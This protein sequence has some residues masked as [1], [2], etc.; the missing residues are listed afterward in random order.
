MGQVAPCVRQPGNSGHAPRLRGDGGV[1][2]A[3]PT[4]LCM[5]R[6]SVLF[7]AFVSAAIL[8]A[9]LSPG[10]PASAQPNLTISPLTWNVIGLDSNNVNVG[11]DNFP[12]GARVCNTGPDPA[13]NVT[14]QLVWDS[15]N[16]YVR[17][18]PGS[19][20]ATGDPNTT[21]PVSIGTLAGGNTCKDVYFEVTVTRN[22]LAYDTTRRY[23]IEVDSDET[24]PISTPTP[25]ELYVEHLISQNR[26]ATT[27]VRLDG[28]SIPA[29]GT[30][31]LVVGNTYT[32]ELI[33]QTATNGY[34][35]IE[36]FIN[37]PNTIFRTNSVATTYTANGGT[38][39]LAASKL[40]ADGCGWV[41]DP[42]SPNYRACSST[43]KYGGGISVSYNVTII[44]GGGTTQTLNTLIYDFS[45]SSYHYNADFST[46]ARLAAIID[47]TEL[48]LTKNFVPDPTNVNGVSALTFTI[49]N[50]NAAAISGLN[51]TDTFPTTPGAM[52]V[53]SPSGATTT[54]CGTPTFAPLAGAASISF[55]NG[56]VAANSTCTIKVNVTVPATGT[57]TNTSNH[58]FVATAD[59]GSFA[60]DTLTVNDSPPPAACTPGFLMARWT[61]PTGF[62]VSSPAPSTNNVGSASAS[63][64]AGVVPYAS[65]FDHTGGSSLSWGSDGAIASGATLD[66]ANND[67]FE[68]A[69]NTTGFSRVILDFWAQRR[70][71]NGPEGMAVYY[72][73]SPTPPGTSVYNNPNVLAAQNSWI[74][75]GDGST[76][77]AFNSGLNPSG[78][79]YFRIYGFNAVNQVSGADLLLDDVSFTGCSKPTLSKVFAPNPVAVGATSTLTFTVTNLNNL[80]NLTGI[81]FDDTLTAGLTVA[82]GS[83]SQCG[84]TLTTTAPSTISFS[85]GTLLAGA[86]CNVPVTVTATTA[87]PHDNVSGFV[88][89][90]Q[91]GANTS[92]SGIASASLTAVL[93]PVI[94]KGF[95]P[96]PIL[97]GGAS[98]LTFTLT[99]PNP[100]NTLSGVVFSDTFP[101]PPAAPGAMVVA[102]PTGASTSGCGAPTY[103]P[104]AGAGSVSF[105]AGTI[106]AGGTCTV[107][108]NVT[109]PTVGTYTNTSGN[110]SHVIN[111]AT[112]N[113]NT[114]SDSLT[115][116]PP[117]P[118]IGLLKEVGATVSG[119]WL[120]FL[121]VAE[122]G[123]VYYRFTIENLGDVELSPVG[124]ADPD[125]NTS[126]CT[127]PDPLPAPSPLNENHIATCVVV[128]PPLSPIVAVNGIHTNT[129]MATGTS[130]G[131]NYTDT[132][133]ARYATTGLTLAKSVG[134]TFY[135]AVGDVLSYSYVVTNS[136]SAPLAGPVTVSDDKSTNEVCPDVSTVGDLD[137]FLDPGDPV[138]S[139]TCTATYTVTLADVAAGSVTN[140]ATA[141][142]GGVTSN[143]ASETV[144]YTGPTLSPTATAV[145]GPSASP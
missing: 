36:T 32:I 13:N 27:N 43:G 3:T 19:L 31:V 46:S 103:A 88:S 124:I 75:I 35:Q 9:I 52:V 83:S 49:T 61:F 29:G 129:A 11:P 58:L 53:A 59:T 28:V 117:N 62:T 92:P 74:H 67:Y 128:L 12:V 91:T 98:T 69:V 76:A 85:G 84:G 111:A 94:A 133:F 26:N 130:G 24:G 48:G 140:T 99:N 132:S 8:G 77:I 18:R 55:S 86:S 131:T 112:V 16:S 10:L 110:V 60:T 113:G 122:G 79:T 145:E 134:E 143:I 138:E 50:P 73:T 70:S 109:V 80:I 7:V 141:S 34:E 4:H 17:L 127:W 102:S 30:M 1:S 89:S 38:D 90:T 21:T 96:D 82:T 54:G 121:P 71:N 72:G 100:N 64:G 125:V 78:L 81:A 114:A 41:N 20:G 66:T 118:A 101:T 123:E 23:H 136:G 139:I 63:P 40:Y 87:G 2:G 126:Q 120:S 57:Y 68:F 37:F 56:S 5:K 22:P 137:A 119:P 45:G 144:P 135:Q 6:P 15:A 25:R 108:V 47:P 65:S 51:F 107:T 105:S 95:A 106:A 116:N 42:N 115:A 142:A 39:P 93:P 44:S 33:G 97:A 104:V 14:V